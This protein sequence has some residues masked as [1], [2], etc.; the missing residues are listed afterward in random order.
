MSIRAVFF[1]LGGVI[2]R[3]EYQ[4]PRQQLADASAWNT[5]I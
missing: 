3:T 1:D 2:V 4:S 5:T